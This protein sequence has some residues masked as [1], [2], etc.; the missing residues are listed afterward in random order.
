MNYLP[1]EALSY[2]SAS[3]LLY[4]LSTKRFVFSYNHEYPCS[5]SLDNRYT[6]VYKLPI[7]VY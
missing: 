6:T 7:I 3:L 5:H 1:S 2:D 4:I